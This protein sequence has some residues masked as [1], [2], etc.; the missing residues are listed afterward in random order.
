MDL[1]EVA[2]SLIDPNVIKKKNELNVLESCWKLG[3]SCKAK[4]TIDGHVIF[5]LDSKSKLQYTASY[6]TIGMIYAL[7]PGKIFI[8]LFLY[9]NFT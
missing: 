2:S 6:K 5:N 1:T 3:D 4:V 8:S 9:Y 7:R